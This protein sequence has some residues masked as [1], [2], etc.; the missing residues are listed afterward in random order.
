[1]GGG[2]RQGSRGSRRGGM[3]RAPANNMG[4]MPGNQSQVLDRPPRPKFIEAN[5]GGDGQNFNGRPP[6]PR[7]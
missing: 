3:K 2:P 4:P 5:Q 6:M 7:G 1:M